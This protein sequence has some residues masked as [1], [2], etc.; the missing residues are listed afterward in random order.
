MCAPRREQFDI[1]IGTFNVLGVW[2]PH[3]LYDTIEL[4]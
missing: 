3:K 2:T 1:F 4:I